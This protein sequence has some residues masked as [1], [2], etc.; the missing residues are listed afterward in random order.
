MRKYDS[1]NDGFINFKELSAG[2]DSD[3]IKFSHEEKLALMKHLDVDC[4]GVISKDELF[5]ALV[6]DHRYRKN[7]HLPK[8]NVDHLL[9]RIRQGAEK[10][11]SVDEF[12]R[13][14]FDRMDTDRNGMLSF[15]ELSTGLQNMGI[16]ISHKEKH[17][18]M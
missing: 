10:F 4:D 12:V 9:K 3:N 8:I 1:D 2:L 6:I 14:I 7:H 13:V 5:D 15:G 16:V 11:K 17:A 18:L